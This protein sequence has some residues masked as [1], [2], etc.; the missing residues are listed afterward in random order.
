MS[1]FLPR[2][3]GVGHWAQLHWPHVAKDQTLMAFWLGLVATS[4]EPR[5]QCARS[6]H[7]CPQ[8]VVGCR[9]S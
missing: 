2:G 5:A 9:V 3:E 1:S 4:T 8:G 6:G 7:T